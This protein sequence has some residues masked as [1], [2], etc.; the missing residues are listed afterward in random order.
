MRLQELQSE[1]LH[2]SRLSAMGEMASALAHEVNQPLAAISN[3]MKGSRRLLAGIRDPVR[4]KDRGGDGQGVRTGHPRR[5]DHP[6]TARL[7]RARRIGEAARE[8]GEARRRRCRPRLG[9]PA[10]TQHHGDA[11]PGVGRLRPGRPR[12][13]P[14]GAGEPGAQRGRGHGGERTPGT[15]R[16]ARDVADGMVE[17]T[18]S[19]T[20]KGLPDD[21]REHLFRPFF[22]TKESGMGVGLSIS[23][24]IVEAHGG[25]LLAEPNASGGATFRF[26]LPSASS[27]EFED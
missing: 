4:A 3:Y 25:H 15:D 27:E 24:S 13:D 11:G 23:R 5:P 17:I 12:P 1:L 7:R 22:T 16:S 8:L 20:G 19:D 10:R 2:V 6:P 9:G 21:V 18:V 14:A 26:T